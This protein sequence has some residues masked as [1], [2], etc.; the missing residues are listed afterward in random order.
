MDNAQQ[1]KLIASEAV[2]V[3][4]SVSNAAEEF[5][6]R[7]KASSGHAQLASINAFTDTHAVDNM[8]EISSS[9]Q[10]GYRALQNEP[11]IARVLYHDGVDSKILYISRKS[12]LNL[13]GV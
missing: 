4:E 12:A 7:A 1:I 10:A 9:I 6:N 5:A 11:A 13:G 2:D 8:R 3:M